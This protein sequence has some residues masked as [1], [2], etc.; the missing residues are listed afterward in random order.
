MDSSLTPFYHEVASGDP[1]SD[2]VIIW[3]RVTPDV[4]EL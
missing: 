3:T 4:P 1:T 2:A